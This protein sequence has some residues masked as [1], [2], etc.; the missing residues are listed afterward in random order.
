MSK[1]IIQAHFFLLLSGALFGANYWIAKGLM[2]D[3]LNPLS[4]ILFRT[5][6][7]SF[8]FSL[9][10][11]WIPRS[12]LTSKEWLLVALCGLT[13]V[14]INQYLF[15]AGLEKSSPI[16]TSVLHTLSP[17]V[18]LLL[19]VLFHG[20]LI[21][22]RKGIGITLGFFGA[23]IITLWGKEI[24]FSS[25]HFIGNLMI[26][27]N[28]VSYSIY[29]ILVKPLMSK[30]NPIF[31]VTLVFIFGFLF[32]L[33]LFFISPQPFISSGFSSTVW[34]SL[35]Y[36]VVG[37]TFLT[38]LLT[39]VAIKSLPASTVGFYVY[40]QPLISTSIGIISGREI[41]QGPLI[42]S[43]VLIFIG[44]FFVINPEKKMQNERMRK[45]K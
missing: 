13:G 27:A 31:I 1:W 22:W 7:A 11:P 3:P 6:G 20:E 43:A 24:H 2:P 12:K 44:I 16:E 38:Y 35:V 4:I 36:V 9:L 41:P 17:L 18:V 37:T 28:I 19:A 33:P 40:L 25:S 32:F 42:V 14:T 26:I 30:H 21:N 45:V 5:A 15:F 39:I 10:L 23:L 29:L 8:L 34:L